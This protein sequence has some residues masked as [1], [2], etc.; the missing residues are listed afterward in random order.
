MSLIHSLTLEINSS[1]LISGPLVSPANTT[2]FT[3]V[4]NFEKPAEKGPV[5]LV[6]AEDIDGLI[7]LLENEAKVL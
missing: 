2:C 6:D 7:D 4:Q 1:L 5:K 3:L